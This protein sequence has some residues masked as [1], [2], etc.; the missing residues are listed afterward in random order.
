MSEQGQHMVSSAEKT[1]NYLVQKKLLQSMFS[2][3]K[4]QSDAQ[5]SCCLLFWTSVRH[6]VSM[7]MGDATSRTL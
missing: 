4:M 1:I 6:D 3:V 2:I 5:N 7:V